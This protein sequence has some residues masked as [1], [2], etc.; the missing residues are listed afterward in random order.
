M[1]KVEIILD[2]FHSNADEL[3]DIQPNNQQQALENLIVTYKFRHDLIH[4]AFCALAGFDDKLRIERR[5][6]IVFDCMSV[7][8]GRFTP[9]AV[10]FQTSDGEMT[11][12]LTESYYIRIIDFSVSTRSNEQSDEK[13]KKYA[14]AMEEITDAFPEKEV[15][16]HVCSIRPDYSDIELRF[17]EFCRYL[18]VSVD[19][20]DVFLRM[21]FF[22]DKIRSSQEK[23]KSMIQDERLIH[24]Y[25]ERE[26]GSGTESENLDNIDV[27]SELIERIEKVY[28]KNKLNC[29]RN[30]VLLKHEEWVMNKVE[31]LDH[32]KNDEIIQHHTSKFEDQCKI[33]NE[34]LKDEDVIKN[35]SEKKT[36]VEKI[37][38]SIDELETKN[39]KFPEQKSKPIHQL[40]TPIWS[41]KKA[42]N[43]RDSTSLPS[44]LLNKLRL[45]QSQILMMLSLFKDTSHSALSIQFVKEIANEMLDAFTGDYSDF[46]I[47][48]FNTGNYLSQD[49]EDTWR[50]SYDKYRINCKKSHTPI[51]GFVDFLK[52]KGEDVPKMQASRSY[53]QKMFRIP[54]VSRSDEFTTF[55]SKSH[56]GY[57]KEKKVSNKARS[58]CKFSQSE[59]VEAMLD[60]LSEKS[61]PTP[62]YND[63]YANF[64]SK[65]PSKDEPILSELKDKMVGEFKPIMQEL[66]NIKGYQY[67]LAQSLVA[68]QLMHYNQFT[69]PSNTMS[70]F[71]CG[72]S[73]M[74][75]IINNS[76]HDKGKD[77]GKAFMVIGFTDDDRWFMNP[78]GKISTWEQR[79]GN[80][81]IKMFCTEWR[82]IETYKVT[83][84]KDQ[85][86]CILS[87]SMNGLLRNRSTVLEYDH[88]EEQDDYSREVIRHHFVLK[89]VIGLTTNQRIAE[90]LADMRYAI[91]ASFSE[92]SEI[93]RLIVDKFSPPYNTSMEVW[94]ASRMNNLKKQAFDFLE[95]GIRKTYFKQP[96]FYNGQRSEDSIGGKFDIPSIWTGMIIH[97]LQDLLDDMFIY[98]HT[99]KE[100]SSIHHE[101][102]KAINTIL[103][104][105]QKY[106][107][108]SEERKCGYGKFSSIKEMLMD[109]LNNIGHNSDILAT[110]VFRTMESIKGVDWENRMKKHFSEPISNITSTKAAIPEYERE[111]VDESEIHKKTNKSKKIK[112]QL[113]KSLF[114][115][116]YAKYTNSQLKERPLKMLRTKI[117]RESSL[118]NKNRSK[119][120]DCILDV[121]EQNN[122]ISTV[123][124]M[125]EWNVSKN[126]SK[127]LADI[128]IKA[129]YGAK[130]EFYVINVG[131]KSCARVLENMFE[132]ICKQLPNEMISVPGDK[133]LLKMQEFIN[134]TL[135]RKGSNDRVYFVNGDCT[136]WSAAETMECFMS[137]LR[138][139]S[140]HISKQYIKYMSTVI[141]MWGN[142]DITIPISLLQN[143]FF[144]TD[145]K[146]KYLETH[147]AT[148]NSDQNFLQGMF[149]YM[150]SFKAVC[151]SNLTRDVWKQIRP[152]S[153]LKMEHME[154]SDDYS[155]IIT[156]QDIKELEEMRLLHRIIMR[157]HGFNDSV[158]KTNTQQFLM[159][160][161]SLVSLNGHMTYPHIKKL[162]ECGMN[163]GCTGYR[164]D[165]DG[166]M[167]RVGEAVRVG[168]ILTSAYFMQRC[169]LA[170]VC[171]AYSTLEGQ[172]NNIAPIKSLCNLPVELFG[173]PDTHPIFSLLCK[174]STN[175]YRLF[176]YAKDHKHKLT[177]NNETF[178]TRNDILM[179]NL[180]DLEI[181]ET[182]DEKFVNDIEFTEGNRLYHP[183]Y[184]FDQENKLI[185]KIREKVKMTFE[186]NL[187]FWAE[188]KTYNF[189]KPK[190]R[191]L[192]V[193]W[194][195]AMYF[196]HSFALAYSR[197][198]RAQVT[199]RLST[200]TS[201]ECCVIGVTDEGDGIYDSIKGYIKLFLTNGLQKKH[202]GGSQVLSADWMEIEKSSMN[203]DST[204]SSMYSFFRDSRIIPHGN[205]SRMTIST[206]TPP[207][208]NWLNIDNSASTLS[209]YMFN[210]DDFKRDIR[211]HKGLASLNSDRKVIET[212]YGKE[213]SSDTNLSTIKSVYTDITLSK[214]RRNLCMSY[215]N[216]SKTLEDFMSN[217][218]EFGSI[219]K[220]R[221]QVVTSGVKEAVN[222]HSGEKYFRKMKS[223]TK[224]PNRAMIDDSALLYSVMKHSSNMDPNDIRLALNNM[225]IQDINNPED[226]PYE[227]SK[228]MLMN[229]Q[230]LKT[231][232]F[233]IT[234]MKTF[235]FMKAFMLSDS[236]DLTKLASENLV[237]AYEYQK[238]T[239][240]MS[241]I[242][243]EA[244]SFEYQNANFRGLRIKKTGQLVIEVDTPRTH[245]LTDAYLITQKL[246][247]IIS[248]SEL[249]KTVS[250]ISLRNLL[251]AKNLMTIV[252]LLT[253]EE[254]RIYRQDAKFISSLIKDGRTRQFR[255]SPISG[256]DSMNAIF[257]YVGDI[258]NPIVK[259]TEPINKRI[260]IEW[261]Q[262]S[263]YVG[264]K[265]LFTLPIL[266]CQQSNMSYLKT[267]V[268]VNGLTLNWWLSESRLR[269]FVH[270]DEI[271]VTKD[272]FEKIGQFT[273]KNESYLLAISS[274]RH[275]EQLANLPS[276]KLFL[277]QS[278]TIEKLQHR[279]KQTR[280]TMEDVEKA[281]EEENRLKEEESNLEK[282]SNSIDWSKAFSS[283]GVVPESSRSILNLDL[284]EEDE[285]NDS[286]EGMVFNFEPEILSDE[287]DSN[288]EDDLDMTE[289]NL[290]ELDPS[291]LE[292][293]IAREMK[294]THEFKT[295]DVEEDS[296]IED[297]DKEYIKDDSGSSN[298]GESNERYLAFEEFQAMIPK[299][300]TKDVIFTSGKS[301]ST[302]KLRRLGEPT[303][304][305]IR[306]HYVDK[307][308]LSVIKTKDRVAIL[309]RL[310][311]M[312]ELADFMSD[313][314][315]L[316]A[317]T[318]MSNILDSLGSRDEWVITEDFTL[319]FDKSNNLDIFL[320][321]T[322][323]MPDESRA[324][325]LKKGGK[326]T[327]EKGIMY[328]LIPLTIDRKKE[329]LE[330]LTESMEIKKFVNVQ[331]LEQCYIRMYKTPF[332]RIGLATQILS[333]LF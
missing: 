324:K 271:S 187:V 210:F 232:G 80:K 12:N 54:M 300:E 41:E 160:F 78:F 230:D 143:T 290:G 283:M 165:V 111:L 123:F 278:K 195:R 323:L 266:G 40:F 215:S 59:E 136:K 164:D 162:K 101:N 288:N 329:V 262:N 55:W 169:H 52:T 326:I 110:S 10:V 194:M 149:N 227:F 238:L 147:K 258:E 284:K 186:E 185:K 286:D 142:K 44:S 332:K 109:P 274:G 192:L 236:S 84:L 182:N 292:K 298:S 269:N 100:P 139:F 22:S 117:S 168:S 5:L 153:K 125:A 124:D 223:T 188:H 205:H 235:A 167:S 249:E 272:V 18:G 312:L 224:N 14:S 1:E 23:L 104:Y 19:P 94:I 333:E 67:L 189:L 99:L 255:F 254:I 17:Y 279:I 260:T 130:R 226:K 61:E 34:L 15:T 331:P 57:K 92:Y 2:T 121:I 327:Y 320:K 9:D 93:E 273:L 270:E 282:K 26:F 71:T 127:T 112:V 24:Q 62:G 137:M 313:H 50:E 264:N 256:D 38:L 46:N 183:R 7:K 178:S 27:D 295:I 302:Q 95:A 330:G 301:H 199:L 141:L 105:Q 261:D 250:T 97:D 89:V 297:F 48:M 243:H 148:L 120:H 20:G 328:Y 68:E 113:Q 152:N 158:K 316:L 82:R 138:G 72:Y 179:R 37:Q 308:S 257:F 180:L 156:T 155:L 75:Y 115:Q 213:L 4:H 252:D 81:D 63:I 64:F 172:R 146:T 65:L 241:T 246:F 299:I 140:G 198:S 87:T 135:S 8:T 118:P 294:G 296:D 240:E 225:H 228:L 77:V 119:V 86:F 43:L 21:R 263:V 289:N 265:K 96:V 244:V 3:L 33:F 212:Y 275:F 16:L 114:I 247:G 170:N 30:K 234:E 76:Y 276:I 219:Y 310:K 184:T 325:I 56:S 233:S 116:E 209:Q 150:S 133:K 202:R 303:Q 285:D 154:H 106:E 6:D 83:F 217:H 280:R 218:L 131:S 305:I 204:V 190:N 315:L 91:M 144:T 53:K 306:N 319:T 220:V 102:V 318:L 122:H 196:R 208:I 251:E 31:A 245:L 128:C 191:E 73:N 47:E 317:L 166:A 159:E 216:N 181:E 157:C 259:Q 35:Y 231:M 304:Y 277:D 32:L 88:I 66:K 222:P 74:L 107:A 129:Q 321:Y 49:D 239:G 242:F 197:N 200:Y 221:F 42:I 39:E 214:D 60:M 163:L 171:R 108:M 51:Q 174:G 237:F 134:Q 36:S 103:E 145:D 29:R 173:I 90:M 161:I 229:L 287:Y 69:L 126:S 79:L 13:F 193:S 248:Q 206:L 314:E 253:D 207:K 151:S 175:N 322:G 58:S 293:L 291:V 176:K 309:Y 25:F 28:E 132:E 211:E 203:S 268:D 85:F 201:K 177:I 281:I 11:K 267:D 45:E 70:F 98:V 307:S 311:A